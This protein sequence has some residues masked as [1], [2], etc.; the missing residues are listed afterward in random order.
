LTAVAIGGVP[1][2]GGGSL[3]SLAVVLGGAAAGFLVWNWH[4]ARIILGDVGSIPIGFLLGWL[5]LDLALSGYLAAALI[6]PLNH[7][8]DATQTLIRRFLTVPEPWKPHRQHAYQRAV[9]AGA[10]VPAVVLRIAALDVLLI[11]LAVLSLTQP[12]AALLV[13]VLATWGLTTYHARGSSDIG[14]R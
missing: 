5:M 12:V 10:S 6:L 2:T 1:A 3:T 7:I 11:A 4:P 9:L 8:F 14:V 13:A